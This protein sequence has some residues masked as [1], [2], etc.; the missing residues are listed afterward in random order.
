MNNFTNFTNFSEYA[1]TIAVNEASKRINTVVLSVDDINAYLQAVKR[2]IPESIADTIYLTA[3]YKLVSQ[4]DIDDVRNANKGQLNK[5][6]FKYGISIDEMEDLWESLK[7]IKSNLRLLPQYQ[8]ISERKAFMAGKLDMSD[9]TIDLESSSGRNA[10][11]K[12][13]MSMVHK[14]VNTYVGQSRLGKPEL[15]SAA[16]QGFTDAMND[17]RKNGDDSSVPFKTYAAYRVKQ[18]IL[19]DINTYSY[20]VSTNW[21][22]VKKMGSSMLSAISLDQSPKDEDGEF[23]Q[24]RLKFLG[25]EP[26]YNLTKSEEHNWAELYK[27]IE[28]TFKQRDIDIFYRYFGLKGYAKEKAKDIAKSLGISPSLVTGIVKEVVLKTLK[29]NSKAMDILMDLSA[30]YNESI[31][32]DIL[33]LDKSMMIEAIL[34]DD[35]FILLEELTKWS[36]KE[37]YI[38]TI[39]G[40]FSMM[41]KNEVKTISDILSKDFDYLDKMFKANKKVIVKFLSLVYPFETFT[42]KSD[43]TL[44]EYM[45]ELSELY[46]KYV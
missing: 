31:M 28:N 32:L 9:I 45:D 24:D 2:N 5:L 15:M 30:S 40:V 43:V 46:R 16:L 29:K 4:K 3:K 34:S 8:T 39:E 22:G 20:S 38:N 42:R 14:I 21:Y 27:I 25:N 36:N 35:T 23:K 17:W 44:L 12:Q 41:D 19:N 6:A 10:C 18:Q 37:I 33:N 1:S 26:D 13:Y 11:A 7:S